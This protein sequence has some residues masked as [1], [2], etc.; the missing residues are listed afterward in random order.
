MSGGQTFES[1]G[2]TDKCLW[3]VPDAHT[4]VMTADGEGSNGSR[5]R[6]WKLELQRLADETGLSISVCHVHPGTSKWNTGEHRLCSFMTSHW[7]GEPLR[8]DETIVNLIAH[9][10]TAKGLTVTCRLDRRTHP[11]GRNVSDEAMMRVNVERNTCH[12]EWNYVIK[13]LPKEAT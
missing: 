7:R 9:T 10:T 12:G 8:D 3:S 1:S 5:L 6:R 2:Q 13:P 11:T 4:L